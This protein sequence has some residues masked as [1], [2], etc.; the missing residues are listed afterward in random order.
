[1]TPL[2]VL[3]LPTLAE[4]PM[5]RAE[6][7]F[8]RSARGD[9]D[10]AL[11]VEAAG[12]R[13]SGAFGGGGLRVEAGCGDLRCRIVLD[14]LAARVR[15]AL[16]ALVEVPDRAAPRLSCA[17]RRAAR[18]A[19][20]GAWRRP[21]VILAAAT[22]RVA[23]GEAA[24]RAAP[25]RFAPRGLAARWHAAWARDPRLVV[26]GD[27]PADDPTLAALTVA[28]DVGID[29]ADAG[30]RAGDGGREIAARPAVP[31]DGGLSV[32]LVDWPGAARADVALLWSTGPAEALRD[33]GL[34]G[35]FE[36]RLV[37]SLRETTAL[38]YDVSFNA[39]GS[40]AS[41]S[42]NVS[43]ER[44]WESLTLALA[45]TW[46]LGRGANPDVRAAAW[47]RARLDHAILL[48]TLPGRIAAA[49]LPPAPPPPTAP[50]AV[51]TVIGAVVVG[52]ADTIAPSLAGFPVERID[53]C[54]LL[55]GDECPPGG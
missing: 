31:G 51:P 18:A 33:R 14:G 3:L 7:S 23:L 1:L 29:P 50:W 11:L 2:A 6:L 21:D 49:T 24:P 36:S 41:A 46:E 30:A 25:P 37:Q 38:T 34:A 9:D 12:G 47:R 45:E 42:W 53:R 43:S 26:A 55:Y 54:L 27:V 40:W 44:A 10:M 17:Q 16:P 15:A 13:L 5:A 20:R 35:D 28:A 8:A 52:D 22:R 19:W 4:G 48:D 39:S 32:L